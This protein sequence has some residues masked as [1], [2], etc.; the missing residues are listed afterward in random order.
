MT[1]RFQFGLALIAVLC[2][3]ERSANL[4]CAAEDLVYPVSVAVDPA[5]NVLIADREFHGVWKLEGEQL[6]VLFKGSNKFRTPLNAVRCVALD[7]DG[8][9][10][11]G[12]SATRDIYRFDD[13][14]KPQPLTDEGKGYGQI[15]IPMDIVVDAEGNFLV[16]DLELHRIVKVPKAGGKVTEFAA[17]NAPRGMFYDGKKQLWVVSGR[18]LLRIGPDGKPET[19]V[20]EGVFQFP[21]T[22]AVSADGTAFV[23]DNYAQAIWR[24]APGKQPEKWVSGD[25][26]VRPVGMDL[27]GDK[28]LVVDPHAKALLEIDAAGKATRRVV[29]PAS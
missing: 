28:L 23:C 20:G 4:A 18:K 29:K 8:K 12:D 17:V 22:V 21:Q 14:G 19:V 10:V 1:F 7:A 2:V 3:G 6:K 5:G 11:A 27:Q 13:A 15:G 24:I 9:V 16:S 25:P 26:L